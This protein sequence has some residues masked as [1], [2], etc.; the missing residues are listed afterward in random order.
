MDRY[1]PSLGY[2][3]NK[4]DRGEIVYVADSS[5]E[6][7]NWSNRAHVVPLVSE[8]CVHAGHQSQLAVFPSQEE[9]KKP[10]RRNRRSYI[11]S[12]QRAQFFR[13]SLASVGLVTSFRALFQLL[14]IVSF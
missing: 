12:H 14:E 4:Q 10:A 6:L 9:R 13:Y 3:G 2:S 8:R 1:N 5:C 7:L 11:A